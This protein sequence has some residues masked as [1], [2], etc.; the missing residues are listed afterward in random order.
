MAEV[1]SNSVANERIS[2]E[3][4]AP[5]KVSSVQFDPEGDVIL[6]I[7]FETQRTRFQVN[8]QSLCLASSVFRVM[9]GS[10]AHFKEGE[11][12]RNRG[13]SSPPIDITLG[14]DDPKA[15][16]LLLRI[17]HHQ[18]DWVPRTLSGD[19][20]YEVAIVCDKYD[21]RQVLGL[22]LDQWIPVDTK[23]GGNIGGDKWLFIAYAFG[24]EALFTKLSKELILNSTLDPSGSLLVPPPPLDTV[25]AQCSFNQY[26]PS[27][28]LGT[29]GVR[30][31]SSLRAD[32]LQRRF[33]HDG[34]RP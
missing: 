8:S 9:F 16:A 32:R 27:S 33:Q 28:I 6:I 19:Q 14:D 25:G 13:A 5:W 17:A 26:I 31:N 22:W 24:S 30:F 23:C 18:Y 20:L 3:D 21:M 29:F 2:S 34:S 10:N 11:A 1:H 7:P 15:L 4:P 12:L